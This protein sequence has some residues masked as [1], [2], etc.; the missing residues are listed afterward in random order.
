MVVSVE[1]KL[2]SAIDAA[3]RA[4]HYHEGNLVLQQL[5]RDESERLIKRSEK[6]L[7][8]AKEKLQTTEQALSQYNANQTG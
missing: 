1:T 4:I 7:E 5:K 3:K 8:E 2:K 6:L